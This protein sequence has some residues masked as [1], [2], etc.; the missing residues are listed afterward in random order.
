LVACIANKVFR[1]EVN[2]IDLFFLFKDW[3][4]AFSAN[5]FKTFVVAG[6]ANKS[7]LANAAFRCMDFIWTNGALEAII[8]MNIVFLSLEE[9]FGSFFNAGDWLLA[10][11]ALGEVFRNFLEAVEAVWEAKEVFVVI[12]LFKVWIIIT[13]VYACIAFLMVNFIVFSKCFLWI[14]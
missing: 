1:M 14:Y 13:T 8:C 4:I 10:N 11:N 9:E 6:T 7:I 3:F 2:T 12:L 5:L